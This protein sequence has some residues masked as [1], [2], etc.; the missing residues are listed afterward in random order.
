MPEETLL[1]FHDHGSVGGS[2]PR[3][4]GDAETVLADFGKAGIDIAAL[5]A[6]LQT[7]AAKSFVESWQDLLK[8]IEAKSKV[9][10]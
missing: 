5:A 2:V 1:A 3:D 7:D 6:K 4:G 10:A 8:A 9:L